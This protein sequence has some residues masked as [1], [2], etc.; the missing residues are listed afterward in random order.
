MTADFVCIGGGGGG[1]GGGSEL[2]LLFF[3]NQGIVDRCSN[4]KFLEV[5]PDLLTLSGK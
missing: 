3:F 2:L 4:F 1:G 5:G